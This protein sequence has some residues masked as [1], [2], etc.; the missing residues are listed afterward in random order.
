MARGDLCKREG[1]DIESTVKSH[2]LTRQ[3]AAEVTLP[4]ML[5]Y[6]AS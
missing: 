1:F 6:N 5:I 3:I 2:G 4:H